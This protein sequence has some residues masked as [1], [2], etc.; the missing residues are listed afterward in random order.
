MTTSLYRFKI[1]DTWKVCL[2]K[3]LKNVCAGWGENEIWQLAK[4]PS[5]FNS[6]S[7][8]ILDIGV[9]NS[10]ASEKI[11]SWWICKQFACLIMSGRTSQET[12]K[13]HIKEQSNIFIPSNSF[14]VHCLP[15]IWFNLSLECYQWSF[16]SWQKMPCRHPPA[17][18]TRAPCWG[19]KSTEQRNSSAD[20]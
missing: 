4:V 12:V 13:Q 10:P 9:E 7:S 15:V 19:R 17:L 14:E 2:P 1:S 6:Q 3:N 20:Q 5:T 18:E 16:L 11:V 8:W